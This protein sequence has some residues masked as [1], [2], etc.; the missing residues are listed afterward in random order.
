MRNYIIQDST[1]AVLKQEKKTIIYN[2]ENFVVF[3]KSIKKI[4]DENC[5]LHGSNL[6]GRIKS[7]QKILNVKYRVPILI[8]EKENI[9]LLP[10]NNMRDKECL[11]IVANKIIDY[12][13]NENYLEIKCINNQI[14]KTKISKYS[15]EKMIINVMKL[16]N[17]LKWEIFLN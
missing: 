5:M 8:S 2:V 7:V 15:F 10:M 3:N 6:S 4:L 9:I 16:N 17:Y 13:E 1:I 11:Y 12:T 14:F